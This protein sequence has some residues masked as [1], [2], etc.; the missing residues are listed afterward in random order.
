M[1]GIVS[2]INQ[3]I[4]KLW[5]EWHENL[6]IFDRACANLLSQ[7]KNKE[8]E[9]KRIEECKKIIRRWPLLYPESNAPIRRNGKK[10]GKEYPIGPG[11]IVF[12]GFNPSFSFKNEDKDME[13][14]IGDFSAHKD[15]QQKVSEFEREAWE[16][17]PYFSPIYEILDRLKETVNKEKNKKGARK[18]EVDPFFH[19]DLLFMRTTSQSILKEL[20]KIKYGVAKCENERLKALF[21]AQLNISM[22]LVEKLNPKLIVVIN[23]LSSEIIRERYE[24][25]KSPLSLKRRFHKINLNR[26]EFP[27]LF[28]GMLSGQ[29]ALDTHSRERLIWHMALV[30]EEGEE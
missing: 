19:V 2:S 3:Q 13:S 15:K 22:E 1:N 16:K 24:G 20:F 18:Y 8:R 9:I 29:R 5:E 21:E 26:K 28:S 4:K 23:A 17:Y 6:E 7:G 25:L 14:I 27:I 11:G 30:L 12:I 10:N